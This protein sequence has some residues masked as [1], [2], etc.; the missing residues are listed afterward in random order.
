MSY[1][2]EMFH[3]LQEVNRVTG[4]VVI[5]KAEATISGSQKLSKRQRKLLRYGELLNRGYYTR[6]TVYIEYVATVM[7]QRD[8]KT[9]RVYNPEWRTVRANS[10]TSIRGDIDRVL[11]R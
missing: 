10:I 5:S 9:V 2:K 7:G 3:L 4:Y 1:G 6:S 11:R 8:R